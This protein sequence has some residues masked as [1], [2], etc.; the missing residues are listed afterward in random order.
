VNALQHGCEQIWM[1][2]EQDAQRNRKREPALAHRHPWDDAV[3]Q[4]REG[5]RVVQ[6]RLCGLPHRLALASW[7]TL[8]DHVHLPSIR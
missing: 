8:V 5:A 6:A 7:G 4:V 2:G 3:D 1:G